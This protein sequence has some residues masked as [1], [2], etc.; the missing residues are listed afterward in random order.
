MRK[1][2]KN[3]GLNKLKVSE[4]GI[5]PEEREVMEEREKL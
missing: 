1:K 5:Q 2:E 3:Q 4:S